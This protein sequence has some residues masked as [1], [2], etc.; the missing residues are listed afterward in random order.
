MTAIA[1]ETKHQISEVLET[2][3]RPRVI[4]LDDHQK[5]LSA[6]SEMIGDV[7]KEAE[8]DRFLIFIG[9]PSLSTEDTLRAIRAP[10]T[11]CRR[12]RISETS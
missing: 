12:P 2:N 9:A 6:A 5:V 3:L 8:E 4:T 10:T 7:L 11:Y 1:E